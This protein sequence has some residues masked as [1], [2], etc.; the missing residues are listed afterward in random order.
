MV[1]EPNKVMEETLE[2]L[3]INLADQHKA[4]EKLPNGTE[5]QSILSRAITQARK[6]QAQRGVELKEK[7]SLK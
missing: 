1:A 5:A 2:Q 6:L 4:A 3:I 7:L